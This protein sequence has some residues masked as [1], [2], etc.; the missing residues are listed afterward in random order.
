VPI[1]GRRVAQAPRTPQPRATRPAAGP[2]P[3]GVAVQRRLALTPA[4]RRAAPHRHSTLDVGWL[5]A[6][7]AMVA[8]AAILGRPRAT[9]RSLRAALELPVATARSASDRP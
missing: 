4:H 7:L 9:R 1:G 2:R 8:A 5:V 3:D 6:C